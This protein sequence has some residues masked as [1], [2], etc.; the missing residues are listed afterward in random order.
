MIYK[1][2]I[3]LILYSNTLVCFSQ[4]E[5]NFTISDFQNYL[6][7]NFH[8][9][10]IAFDENIYSTTIS[11]DI[12]ID[13]SGRFNVLINSDIHPSLFYEANR[14]VHSHPNWINQIDSTKVT[15]EAYI[16]QLLVC[17]DNKPHPLGGTNRKASYSDKRKITEEQILLAS[18]FYKW[19]EKLRWITSDYSGFQIPKRVFIENPS[20]IDI[21]YVINRQSREII[22]PEIYTKDSTLATFS[23]NKKTEYILV[24]LKLEN[25]NIYFAQL[26]F[27]PNNQTINPVYK[28]INLT[29]LEESLKGILK[30]R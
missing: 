22:K 28:L 21:T 10:S 6:K 25:S 15:E 12:L 19:T 8:W 30:S 27:T 24:C 13:S 20:L 4:N 2:I 9:P 5:G 23:L 1:T 3:A 11:Y 14:V 26:A 17:E 7:E 18:E 29:Q 16:R